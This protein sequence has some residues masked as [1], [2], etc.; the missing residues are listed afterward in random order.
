MPGP[1]STRGRSRSAPEKG[2][3]GTV[4]LEFRVRAGTLDPV[5]I[6]AGPFGYTI[7]IPWYDDDPRAAEFNRQ[8]VEKSLRKM[9][10]YGFT[11]C[12]RAAVDRVPR[13][14]RRQAGPRLH[15]RPTRR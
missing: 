6:P 7:G 11:A 13:V 3:T 4:P 15:A 9:R 12:Q 5:D 2:G 14:Q 1:A 10:E 8:M